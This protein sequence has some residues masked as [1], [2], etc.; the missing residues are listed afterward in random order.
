MQELLMQ[1]HACVQNQQPASEGVLYPSPNPNL[2]LVAQ[3]LVH[4]V[5]SRVDSFVG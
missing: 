5:G 1:M 3:R 4:W 2:M